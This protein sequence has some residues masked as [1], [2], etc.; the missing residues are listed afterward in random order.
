MND[1]NKPTQL[2]ARNELSA[3][4]KARDTKPPINEPTTPIT[5]FMKKP[6]SRPMT[7][8]AIQPTSAPKIINAIIPINNLL[9]VKILERKR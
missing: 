4:V 1:Q 5:M 6:L 9:A 7:F 2:K 3:P 8:E